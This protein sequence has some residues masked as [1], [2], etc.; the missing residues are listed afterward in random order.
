MKIHYFRE[1]NDDWTIRVET[2]SEREPLSFFSIALFLNQL[3]K[4]EIRRYKSRVENPKQ[5]PTKFIK[6]AINSP[7]WADPKNEEKVRE[8]CDKF[9][10]SVDEEL[11]ES[12]QKQSKKYRLIFGDRLKCLT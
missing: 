4:E 7:N 1:P 2:D 11:F 5:K 8:I 3:G 10:I 12:A 9:K 6:K